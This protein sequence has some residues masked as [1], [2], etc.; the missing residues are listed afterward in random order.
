MKWIVWNVDLCLP[1][2]LPEKC[3]SGSIHYFHP[4]PFVFASLLSCVLFW[5]DHHSNTIFAFEGSSLSW[6]SSSISTLWCRWFLCCLKD[7]DMSWP[8]GS[9]RTTWSFSLTPSEHPVGFIIHIYQPQH[10]S[11][12][13]CSY[14]FQFVGPYVFFIFGKKCEDIYSIWK[15]HKLFLVFRKM[16]VCL[17]ICLQNLSP[18]WYSLNCM[19]MSFNLIYVER[20]FRGG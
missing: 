20:S 13:K 6:A 15:C 1:W 5:Q 7:S 19:I 17:S 3:C 18:L 12:S 14:C 11:V 9:A 10:W 2:Q 4:I 16:S 8:T